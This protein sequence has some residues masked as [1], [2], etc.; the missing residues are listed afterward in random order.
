MQALGRGKLPL[1]AI[2]SAHTLLCFGCRLPGTCPCPWIWCLCCQ[3]QLFC[4]PPAFGI[5]TP[6]ETNVAL[7][8]D[9][10]T[11]SPVREHGLPQLETT[12]LRE[13]SCS[14]LWEC[15]GRQRK[16]SG[17][18]DADPATRSRD[19]SGHSAAQGNSKKVMV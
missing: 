6:S 18:Q 9:T 17:E 15:L 2:S 7:E 14:A 4:V 8:R 10:E 13:H 12:C 19:G 1:Q 3:L 16:V 11:L 5:V